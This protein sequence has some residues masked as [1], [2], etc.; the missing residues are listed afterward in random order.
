MA[1]EAGVV[2]ANFDALVTIELVNGS[3]LECV[4]DTGFNGL[5]LLPRKFC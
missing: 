3:K 4:I 1:E 2:N 5:L